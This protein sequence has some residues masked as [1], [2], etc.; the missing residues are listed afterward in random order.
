M[1]SILI[2]I[3]YFGSWPEWFPLFLESCRTNPTIQWHIH[4]D[5]P[6]PADPP[7]NVVFFPIQFDAYCAFVSKRLGISFHTALAYKICDLR[8]TFGV[9]YEDET[10]NFDYF[11]YT[12]LDLIYGDIRAFYTDEVLTHNLISTHRGIVSGHFTLFK[13]TKRMREAFRHIPT[14]K[15]VLENPHNVPWDQC[16]DESKLARLCIAPR[17][18]FG[19]NKKWRRAGY[20]KNN[21][22]VEQYSTPFTPSPWIDGRDDHPDTWYWKD[23]R[24]TNNRD[25][26]REFMYLH[27]MNFRQARWINP[28]YKNA[29]YWDSL[30]RLV[31]F[32]PKN[33]RGR[34]IRIGRDGFNLV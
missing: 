30:P 13:N 4:T 1:K 5:C 29:S 9:L 32:D 15:A 8:T 18:L 27:F 33:I 14:W 31:N 11:G 23:G 3:D 21:Y 24:I 22:F 10:Q 6:I 34:T 25:G 16:L 20:W 26:K 17:T 19:K 2:I 7:A 12:D 28:M